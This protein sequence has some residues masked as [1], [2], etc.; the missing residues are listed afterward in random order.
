MFAANIWFFI[1]SVFAIYKVKK[2]LLKNIPKEEK[3][4]RQASMFKHKDK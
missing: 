3:F 4:Q 2:E 1:S